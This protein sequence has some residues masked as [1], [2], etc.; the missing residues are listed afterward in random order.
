MKY[1]N[2]FLWEYTLHCDC[3]NNII[4]KYCITDDK[5]PNGGIPF[6]EP[7][8]DRSADVNSNSSTN[9]LNC[10]DIWGSGPK[11]H[12]L[13][14]ERLINCTN[15]FGKLYRSPMPASTMFDTENSVFSEMIQHKIGVVVC[16]NLHHETLEKSGID[17]ISEY[18]QLSYG[19]LWFPIND[20][21][22]PS[23]S[24]LDSFNNLI[25][26]IYYF[27]ERNVNVMVHCHAGIGRTGL[28][29]ACFLLKYGNKSPSDAI[30]ELRSLV[31]GAGQTQQQLDYVRS[32][33]EFIKFK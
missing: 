28:V 15:H 17:L 23:V 13:P 29:L 33:R 10:I 18:G 16:L 2:P 22:A 31:R 32:Y 5:Q 9:V 12:Q 30:K 3:S 8:Q 24:Q 11:L 6:W 25:D 27:L 26:R 14:L 20:F 7:G 21:E 1:V 19:L 4:Y